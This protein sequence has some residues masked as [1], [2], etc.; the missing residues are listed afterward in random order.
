MITEKIP[1]RICFITVI[2]QFLLY[3]FHRSHKPAS[4]MGI[5]IPKRTK[6]DQAHIILLY[7]VNIRIYTID[8]YNN[9]IRYDRIRGEIV[10]YNEYVIW[11]NKLG[12]ST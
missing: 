7:Y 8:T 2:V 12:C 1:G 6:G 3:Q 9:N 10:T 5:G 11:S 4:V